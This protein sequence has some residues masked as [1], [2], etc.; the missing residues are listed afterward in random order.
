M[1][2][3]MHRLQISLPEWQHQFLRQRARRDGVSVAEIIRLLVQRESEAREASPSENSVWAI[4]GVAEDRGPLIRG[5]PV[6]ESAALYLS[7][8]ALPVSR[9]QAG[10]GTKTTGRAKASGR[11]KAKRRSR[12]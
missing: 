10:R 11:A 8:L 5:T 12:R 2:T 4:A 6:S 1:A 7:D 3:T 9:V